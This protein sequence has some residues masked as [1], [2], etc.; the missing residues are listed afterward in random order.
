MLQRSMDQ[1]LGNKPDKTR[2]KQH[3]HP[4]L[5]AAS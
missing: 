5:E 4:L 2:A 3:K 1:I